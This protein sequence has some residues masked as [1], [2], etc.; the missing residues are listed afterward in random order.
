M[1]VF[2][3]FGGKK[4][5]GEV[6]IERVLS[7][8][9]IR[10]GKIIEREDVRYVKSI[11]LESEGKNISSVLKELQKGNV[12]I[13]NVQ[14]MSHN[15]LLLRAVVKELREACTSLNGDLARISEEKIIL[16]PSG[17]KISHVE[18]GG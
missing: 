7:D 2:A 5:S 1:I 15:K 6:D 3:V 10:E 18:S 4:P 14:A 16:L 13:L 17:M 8:M 9:S 11:P 12:V